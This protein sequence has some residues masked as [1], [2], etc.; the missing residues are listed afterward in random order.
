LKSPPVLSLFFLTNLTGLLKNAHPRFRGDGVCMLPSWFD[1]LT[2][3][4]F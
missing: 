4:D 1:K 2:M 3:T